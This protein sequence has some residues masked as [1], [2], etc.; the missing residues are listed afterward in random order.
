[1]LLATGLG[2]GFVK[3]VQESA[4]LQVT[5]QPKVENVGTALPLLLAVIPHA[6]AQCDIHAD[7][8][9]T[10]V[11]LHIYACQGHY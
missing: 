8:V 3:V 9:P 7:K 2:G 6:P 5:L 10:L 4:D 11:L 1:M